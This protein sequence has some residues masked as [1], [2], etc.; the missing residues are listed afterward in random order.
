MTTEQRTPGPYKLLDYGVWPTMM[1]GDTQHE[2][3]IWHVSS[4]TMGLTQAKID[5]AFIIKACNNH[6]ALL[7]ACEGLMRI[8]ELILY[9]DAAVEHICEAQTVNSAVCAIE[10]AI[11][12]AKEE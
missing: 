4:A 7:A 5:A 3:A 6:D 1:V 8:K 11:A 12:A 10:D 9:C 2:G